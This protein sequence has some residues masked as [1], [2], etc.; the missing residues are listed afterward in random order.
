[1]DLQEEDE[2]GERNDGDIN[3]EVEREYS[4]EKTHDIW[5]DSQE[6]DEKTLKE[7][8]EKFINHALKGQISVH[9]EGLIAA[10]K[11]SKGEL[12]W[13]LYLQRLMGTLES[14]KK[15][16]MTR[17]S[18]RQPQ[19]LDLRGE[20]RSHKAEV[21][22]ALDISGSISDEEFKQAMQEVLHMVKNHNHAIT[23][24]ECDQ[25]IRRV[26]QVKSVKDIRERMK[27][28]GGTRFT[29]VFEYANRKKVNLLV[30]FT[31]GKGEDR[32]Q[33]IPR[34]YKILWVISG[35]GDKLSLK[36][37]YGAVRKLSKVEKKDR[38]SEVSYNGREGYS[39]NS[40]EPS[41]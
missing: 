24:I 11:N 33:V 15:K 9:L 31:D 1:M 26:Y 28:R 20:L 36:E 22:V 10:F 32:L 37:P 39:M 29:P 8:T 14:N 4:P 2:K 35:R 27:I 25:Q 13:H 6:I 7:F 16:T 19:R 40:Q 18:R 5:E 41:V 38:E 30:Y 34:G 12:P 21:A 3:T 23:L 17:R